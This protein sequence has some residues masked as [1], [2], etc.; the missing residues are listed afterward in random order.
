MSD[1]PLTKPRKLLV[2]QV[3]TNKVK[4]DKELINRMIDPYLRQ[5]VYIVK[6]SHF[7]QFEKSKQLKVTTA[8]NL[9][10]YPPI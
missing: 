2:L 3:V 8:E 7:H 4:Q 9:Q 5:K 1:H 10:L 6:L